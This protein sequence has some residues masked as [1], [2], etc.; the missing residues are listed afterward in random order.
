MIINEPR[1]LNVVIYGSSYN[2]K[3]IISSKLI[4]TIPSNIV[5]F[6]ILYYKRK[7]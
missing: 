7:S 5:P 3:D 4:K 2:K 1:I 6:I